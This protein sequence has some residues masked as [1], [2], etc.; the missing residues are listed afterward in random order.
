MSKQALDKKLEDLENLRRNSDADTVTQHL[1][2]TLADRNNYLVGRAAQMTANLE[3]SELIPDLL[4]QFDR[5]MRDPVKTDP[6][7]W[8]KTGIVKALRNLGYREPQVFVDGLRHVQMEPVWGG[9]ADSAAGLRSTCILALV[10]CDL[11]D[12]EVLVHLTAAL[13]DPEKAVRT[14]AALAFGQLGSSAGA[15]PLRLKALLGDPEPEVLAQCFSSLLALERYD[16]VEF[17]ASFLRCDSDDVR[18]EAVCALAESRQPDALVAVKR[19]WNERMTTEI[20]RALLVSLGAS[21]LPEA[22]EFLLAVVKEDSG[23]VAVVAM[24]ALAA[25]RFRTE[26]RE[27]T[28]AVLESKSDSALQ[29]AFEKGFTALQ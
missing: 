24:T 10:D 20:R 22:A 25:S 17:I 26:M 15:L 3:R 5:F 13:A 9:R 6:Q 8:A 7:C 27:R 2:R 11:D 16:P 12:F 29:D 19:F 14:D 4:A 28:A 21:P 23:E 18:L 1:R